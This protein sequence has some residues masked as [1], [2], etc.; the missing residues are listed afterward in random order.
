M[1]PRERRLGLETGRVGARQP[2]IWSPCLSS[3]I[4]LSLNGLAVPTG[5]SWL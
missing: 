1:G 4:G 2:Q 5:I 3:L